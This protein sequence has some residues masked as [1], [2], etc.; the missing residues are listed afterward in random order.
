[1][2]D[3]KKMQYDHEMTVTE[4]LEATQIPNCDIDFTMTVW[5]WGFD[6]DG[7]LV[8]VPVPEHINCRCAMTFEGD[9]VIFKAEKKE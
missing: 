5:V 9:A 7:N 6:E 2:A 8:K 3:T 4:Y 1:M